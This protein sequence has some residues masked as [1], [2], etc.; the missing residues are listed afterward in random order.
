MRLARRSFR[1][2]GWHPDQDGGVSKFLLAASMERVQF[3]Q[4][5]MLAE[6][7]DLEQK[8]LFSKVCPTHL[9]TLTAA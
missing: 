9:H 6:L 4:E 8:G 5:Q 3:Q 2:L 7:K 1:R